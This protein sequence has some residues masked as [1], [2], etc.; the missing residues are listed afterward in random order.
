MKQ[1]AQQRIEHLKQLAAEYADL[2]G[3]YA[4]P[5]AARA[6]ANSQCANTLT[7]V[8]RMIRKAR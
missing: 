1:T 2:A 8:N 3:N 5:A 6:V 7:Q 4:L